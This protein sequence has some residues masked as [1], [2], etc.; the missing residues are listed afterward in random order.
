MADFQKRI[1]SNRSGTDTFIKNMENATPEIGVREG[2]FQTTKYDEPKK[3]LSNKAFILLMIGIFIL[4]SCNLVSIQTAYGYA[5]GSYFILGITCILCYYILNKCAN[6]AVLLTQKGEDAY[7]QWRGLYNYLNSYTL[8]EDR[9]HIELPIWEK[10]LVYA[11]AFGISKKVIKVLK[12]KCP[13]LI[14]SE[15]LNNSFSSSPRFYS[16]SRSFRRTS[17]RTST[18]YRN[19]FSSSSY[20]GYGGRGGG[21][22]RRWSLIK[23]KL[24]V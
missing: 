1:E 7:Q 5:Y 22:G 16:S 10:Y 24:S 17:Y 19:S 21:G 9:T 23:Q 2:Y 4:F 20:S 18:S 3:N 8:M 15:M 12:I 11:T 6:N 14:N 13:D